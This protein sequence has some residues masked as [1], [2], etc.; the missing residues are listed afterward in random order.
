[1]VRTKVPRESHEGGSVVLPWARRMIIRQNSL[2]HLRS[3][4]SGSIGLR[5]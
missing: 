4:D 1:M 3:S 2:I 5:K